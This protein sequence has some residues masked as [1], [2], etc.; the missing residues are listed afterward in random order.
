V[1]THDDADDIHVLVDLADVGIATLDAATGQFL[2]VNARYCGITGLS[3]PELLSGLTL[4]DLTHPDDGALA[5]NAVV[6]MAGSATDA[7]E[8]ELRQVRSDGGLAWVRV[9]GRRLAD[10]GD[11]PRVA[12]VVHDLTAQKHIEDLLRQTRA[13]QDDAEA[14]QRDSEGHTAH[15]SKRW[16][17]ASASSK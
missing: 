15:C 2:S 13:R 11:R 4:A 6:T 12:V 1:R 3:Q 16:T 17:K 7:H 10:A 14:S 8:I 9:R 5:F